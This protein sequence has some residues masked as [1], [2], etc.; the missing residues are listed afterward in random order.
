MTEPTEP[1][2]PPAPRLPRWLSPAAAVGLVAVAAHRLLLAQA[3]LPSV[4]NP[5]EPYNLYYGQQMV[6]NTTLIPQY[7]N[8]PSFIYEYGALGDL[9]GKHLPGLSEPIV[10]PDALGTA[11]I[12]GVITYFVM[13]LGMVA[14]SVAMV[15]LTVRLARRLDPRWWV[16]AVA[17]TTMAV[18]SLMVD[19]SYLVTP[20]GPGAAF[21]LMALVGAAGVLFAAEDDDRTLLRAAIGAGAATGLA[22]GTKYQLV[23]VGLA[24]AACFW[25]RFGRGV[26]RRRET[27]AYLGTAAA[28]LVIS[29][30]AVLL[31][32]GK[33]VDGVRFI[34]KAYAFGRAGQ[35]EPTWWFHLKV[36]VGALGPLLL[37]AGWA[38]R[39]QPKQDGRTRPDVQFRWAL[40]GF[41][42]VYLLL[43][44]YPKVHFA[45]N[46]TPI[47]APTAI[48]GAIGLAD[49]LERARSLRPQVRQAVLGG[50]AAV[51]LVPFLVGLAHTRQVVG[52]PR[53]QTRH[54]IEANVPTGSTIGIENYAPVIDRSRW[55]LVAISNA[56]QYRKPV[57]PTVG[58]LV[59]TREGSGPYRDD[60]EQYPVQSQR[61]QDVLTG[62]CLRF[63]SDSLGYHAEVYA[64][65]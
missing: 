58:Y 9:G 11:R 28:L 57:P 44:S 47:V 46:L 10:H 32:P 4:Y 40:A 6:R 41:T 55:K 37:T 64:R 59:L 3:N 25:F 53:A 30:P 2:D 23:L 1:I 24:V 34:N 16:A 8:Y 20:D 61:V 54:W 14:L 13:R 38:L 7:F 51:L 26:L 17:G 52:D 36:L 5:D 43:A 60:P 29:T 50:T 33:V 63:T 42:V 31:D 12:G 56:G 62:F 18:S 49:L 45:R 39:R 21:V 19:N 27:W 15:W 48:L 22:A 65:C 35:D